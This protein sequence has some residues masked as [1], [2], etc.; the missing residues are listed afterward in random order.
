MVARYDP[1]L[2]V[3]K[4]SRKVVLFRERSSQRSRLSTLHATPRSSALR[5]RGRRAQ[6]RRV[7]LSNATSTSTM[8]GDDLSA[9]EAIEGTPHALATE[10]ETADTADMADMPLHASA[11]EC[12]E[13]EACA[14]HDDDVSSRSHSLSPSA[15]SSPKEASSPG[16]DVEEEYKPALPARSSPAAPSAQA[17]EDDE[18]EVAL[19]RLPR[20]ASSSSR[21]VEGGTGASSQEGLAASTDDGGAPPKLLQHKIELNGEGKTRSLF[22]IYS[23]LETIPSSLSEHLSYAKLRPV[24]HAFL[25]T[26]DIDGLYLLMSPEVRSKEASDVTTIKAGN[27]VVLKTDHDDDVEEEDARHT[28]QRIL[29]PVMFHCATPKARNELARRNFQA[30]NDWL[31]I[32]LPQKSIASV[33]QICLL[34]PQRGPAAPRT[35]TQFSRTA[36]GIVSGTGQGW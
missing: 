11:E 33:T 35:H 9:E 23:S 6:Q 22:N 10:A 13:E 20:P 15:S 31:M 24:S 29:A 21:D 18:D 3:T 7:S 4:D 16:S 30:C 14:V 5:A 17:L 8:E 34:T 26:C 25:T 2:T 28:K 32:C 27:I 19:P 12:E 1:S 36:S